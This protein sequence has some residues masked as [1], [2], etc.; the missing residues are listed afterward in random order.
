MGETNDGYIGLYNSDSFHA[1]AVN[2][3]PGIY[4]PPVDYGYVM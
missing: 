1:G 4:L 2:R 3:A